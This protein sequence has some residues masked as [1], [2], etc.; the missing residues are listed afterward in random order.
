[1]ADNINAIV[2]WGFDVMFQTIKCVLK[3]Q[4]NVQFFTLNLNLGVIVSFRKVSHNFVKKL[5]NAICTYSDIYRDF[6]L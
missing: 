4:W 6:T 5:V 1:M 3:F 2:L